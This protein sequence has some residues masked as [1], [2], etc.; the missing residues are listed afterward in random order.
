M[1]IERPANSVS[2]YYGASNMLDDDLLV[3]G[4]LDGYCP[5]IKDY[6]QNLRQGSG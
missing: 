4:K 3:S 2:F 1:S 5:Y 6:M